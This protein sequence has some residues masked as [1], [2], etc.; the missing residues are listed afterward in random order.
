MSPNYKF[1]TFVCMVPKLILNSLM[2]QTNILQSQKCSD[3]NLKNIVCKGL[4][5]YCY[6][7]LEWYIKDLSN[8]FFQF[9]AVNFVYKAFG[10]LLF[11][12]IAIV[13]RVSHCT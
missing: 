7:I 8:F 3:T 9:E 1:P 6:F 12:L 4:F 13:I 5:L 10:N 2:S 11:L